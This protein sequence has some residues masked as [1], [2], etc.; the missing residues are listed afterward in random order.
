MPELHDGAEWHVPEV[1]YV[2]QH[3]R[4]QLRNGRNEREDETR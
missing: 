3:E 4:V 1:R 2:R